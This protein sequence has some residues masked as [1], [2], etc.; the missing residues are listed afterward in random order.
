MIEPRTYVNK[1]FEIEAVQ[2]TEENISEVADWCKGHVIVGNKEIHIKVQVRLPRNERQTQARY[3]D[4]VL[5]TGRGPKVYTDVA[6][7]KSY[8]LKV[9]EPVLQNLTE[10]EA[11]R[12]IKLVAATAPPVTGVIPEDQWIVRPEPE[13]KTPSLQTQM[14]NAKPGSFDSYI[15]GVNADAQNQGYD[16]V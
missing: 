8:D 14:I 15:K 2:V 13:E 11:N 16:L 12:L 7:H 9:D 3:G 5:V 4:W 10:E 1:P 6:F